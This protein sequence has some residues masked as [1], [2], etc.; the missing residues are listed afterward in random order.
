MT[1]AGLSGETGDSL[2]LCF[3]SFVMSQH[4]PGGAVEDVEVP[5]AVVGKHPRNELRVRS[6]LPLPVVQ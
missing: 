2:P 6:K 3:H 4:D 5:G 1:R